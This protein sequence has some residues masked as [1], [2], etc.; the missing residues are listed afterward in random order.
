MTEKTGSGI[1][2]DEKGSHATPTSVVETPPVVDAHSGTGTPTGEGDEHSRKKLRSAEAV[3]GTSSSPA[4][5]YASGG[6]E[7]AVWRRKSVRGSAGAAA[8]ATGLSEAVIS[9]PVCGQKVRADL[10]GRHLD[11]DCTGMSTAGTPLLDRSEGGG[12]KKEGDGGSEKEQEEVGA[13]DRAAAKAKRE[14]E[15]SETAGGLTALRAE[16]TCPVW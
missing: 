12:S 9:C 10:C 13:T 11:T 2:Q 5:T 6:L 16:L 4:P 14:K 15:A 8:A 3:N 1:E 7:L